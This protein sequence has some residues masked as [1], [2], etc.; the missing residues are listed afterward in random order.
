L[1][2][3][4]GEGSASLLSRNLPPGRTRYPSYRRLGGTPDRSE[5]VRKISPLQGF[6][7]WEF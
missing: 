5:Q 1:A 6:V 4:G 7:T 3:E 2:L